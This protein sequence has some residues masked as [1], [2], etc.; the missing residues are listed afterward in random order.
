MAKGNAGGRPG[1]AEI[2]RLVQRAAAKRTA[3][4]LIRKMQDL[5]KEVERLKARR[6]KDRAPRQRRRP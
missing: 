1:D 5:S 4:E 6:E 3:D 2:N